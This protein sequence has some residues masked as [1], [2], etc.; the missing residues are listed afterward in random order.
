MSKVVQRVPKWLAPSSLHPDVSWRQKL[1][2]CPLSLFCPTYL[3]TCFNVSLKR[4]HKYVHKQTP[5]AFLQRLA[6]RGYCV[7]CAEPH[8]SWRPPPSNSERSRYRHSS[9]F[10]GLSFPWNARTSSSM[11]W[12]RTCCRQEWSFSIRRWSAALP[13]QPV[14]RKLQHVAQ[15][16]HILRSRLS[17]NRSYLSHV[18]F[19]S[20]V[21]WIPDVLSQTRIWFFLT[22]TSQVSSFFSAHGAK[23]SH[24]SLLWDFVF[25]G[26]LSHSPILSVLIRKTSPPLLCR[27]IIFVFHTCAFSERV[28]SLARTLSFTLRPTQSIVARHMQKYRS[29]EMCTLLCG[30]FSKNFNDEAISRFLYLITQTDKITMQNVAN[31]WSCLTQSLQTGA[32]NLKHVKAN[33]DANNV[34]VASRSANTVALVTV[35]CFATTLL[36]LDLTCAQHCVVSSESVGGWHATVSSES[37]QA[38]SNLALDILYQLKKLTKWTLQWPW[39]VVAKGNSKFVVK[40]SIYIAQHVPSATKLR[41]PSCPSN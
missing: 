14:C 38:S 10:G 1:P 3:W 28:F 9:S 36:D 31:L 23:R 17:T 25:V 32:Q 21:L 35:S 12:S 29:V 7:V 11:T 37:Q 20:P 5:C 15:S 4:W 19:S 34:S 33:T 6:S 18:R 16:C 30:C 2:T 41:L 39:E 26:R 8:G 24:G 13:A 22:P 40:A 27:T